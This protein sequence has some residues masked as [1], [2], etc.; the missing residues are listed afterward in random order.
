MRLSF[1]T[2]FTLTLLIGLRLMYSLLVFWTRCTFG[3]LAP[4]KLRSFAKLV[5][6]MQSLQW[7][8]ASVAI[9]WQLEHTKEWPKYGTPLTVN[10]FGASE[11]ILAESAQS[12]GTCQLLARVAETGR[13]SKETSDLLIRISARWLATSKKFAALSGVLTINN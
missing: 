8:G 5:T 6:T 7:V 4:I 2:T 11:A 9:I 10:S 3:Q 12:L 13:F 1:K